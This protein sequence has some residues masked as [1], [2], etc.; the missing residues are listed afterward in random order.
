MFYE[1]IT[2]NNNKYK[3]ISYC[4]QLKWYVKRNNNVV[5]K[6]HQHPPLHFFQQAD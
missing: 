1:T 3:L 4:I 6:D 2:T 5:K